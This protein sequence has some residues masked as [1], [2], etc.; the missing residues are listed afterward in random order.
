MPELFPR[1]S[2]NS[3][4]G[5][6]ANRVVTY[7]ETNALISRNST[8]DQFRSVTAQTL[9]TSHGQIFGQA[10]TYRSFLNFDMSGND[11][12]G[13]S[14]SGNT[15]SSADLI[16]QSLVNV[17]GFISTTANTD[18]KIYVVKSTST[19]HN[20]S[21]TFNDLE[22]WVSSGTY[23]GEVTEYGNINQAAD[24]TLTIN[25]N[26]TAISDINKAITESTDFKMALLTEDDFLSAT[27]GDG[28]GTISSNNLEGL[29]YHSMETATSSYRP[30]LSLTYQTGYSHNVAGVGSSN[31]SSI[32]GIATADISKV[33]GV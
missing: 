14:L 4:D 33:N 32:N 26:A 16:L 24:S 6:S 29:R 5:Y 27:G 8:T 25:L 9:L 23:S 19:N 11:N 3:D 31:I 2:G 20:T 12:A 21:A 10:Y 18:E 30:K 13:D 17:S 7:N 15:V 1:L 28:L 22:G